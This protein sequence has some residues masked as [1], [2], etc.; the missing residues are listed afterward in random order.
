MKFA[1]TEQEFRRYDRH[2]RIASAVVG[3]SQEAI[4]RKFVTQRV[5]LIVNPSPTG[6]PNTKI[7]L[8]VAANLIARFCFK[9]D[10]A[11]SDTCP[12]LVA[13]ALNL[14]RR[15]DTSSHAEFRVVLQPDYPSYAAVLSIGQPRIL[16]TSQTVIDSVG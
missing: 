10:L 3:E 16:Q 12:E 9:V 2:L 11:F 15:I 8:M 1:P 6:S 13:D 14:L 5:L 7:M 4:I